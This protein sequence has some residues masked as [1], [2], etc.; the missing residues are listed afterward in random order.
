MLEFNNALK[1][2]GFN[3][4][5]RQIKTEELAKVR[6]PS[7]ILSGLGKKSKSNKLG[8]YFIIKPCGN[9]ITIFDYPDDI[10]TFPVGFLISKLKQN[11]I[12][13]FPIILCSLDERS[14][15]KMFT[16]IQLERNKKRDKSFSYKEL[17]KFSSFREKIIG[18]FDFGRKPEGSTQKCT[19]KLENNSNSIIKIENLKADCKCS[20][21]KIDKHKLKVNESCVITMKISL[22]EKYRNVA[23]RGWGKI[24]QID[25]QK[26]T[27]LLLL[28]N[29]YSEPRILCKPQKI[30]FGVIEP[31][32]ESTRVK[33]VKILK[34]DSAYNQDI[35]S[36]KSNST[37]VN[38]ANIERNAK[39]VSFDAI[40]D[41]NDF[42]GLM[43][44]RI[45]VFMDEETKPANYFDV[46]ALF[47]L[48]YVISPQSL[49]VSRDNKAK[50]IIKNANG[51]EFKIKTMTYENFPEI[52]SSSCNFRG[53]IYYVFVS[54]EQNLNPQRLLQD[55]LL[56]EVYTDNENNSCT[57]EI[58]VVYIPERFE[59]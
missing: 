43:T 36:I 27:E 6:A 41:A 3:T 34:T 55:N 58:P 45:N 1:A 2:C 26:A 24:E 37:A 50:V 31:T 33:N 25:G 21:I 4:E 48:D 32:S 57:L 16:E 56:V 59:G 14:S 38:I 52:F 7:I 51:K 8:H 13:N 5:A 46:K 11:N 47:K 49:I 39:Y 22:S 9:N 15:K 44:S 42:I 19:F 54:I 20:E 29:G 23:V 17:I 30:D 12:N 28:V 53:N 10:Q 35:I 18:Q 40:L